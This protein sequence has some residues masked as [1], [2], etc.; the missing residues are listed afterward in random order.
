MVTFKVKYKNKTRKCRLQE[1]TPGRRSQLMA[2]RETHIT[3]YPLFCENDTK[4]QNTVDIVG[5]VELD[6][7]SVLSS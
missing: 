3:S 6:S 4:K 5:F 7:A 2:T 1:S